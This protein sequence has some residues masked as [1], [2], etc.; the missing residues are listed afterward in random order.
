MSLV[1]L[2]LRVPDLQAASTFYSRLFDPEPA[3]LRDGYA[4]FAIAEPPLKLVLFQGEPGEDTRMGHLGV[5]VAT[6]DEVHAATGRLADAGPHH[7]GG[8]RHHLLS[9]RPGQSLDPGPRQRTLGGVR[10]ESRRNRADTAT[11]ARLLRRL[12]SGEGGRRRRWLLLTPHDQRARQRGRDGSGGPVAAAGRPARP[13][14]DADC[15]LGHRLLRLRRPQ[16]P[17]HRRDRLAGRG[18]HRGVLPR[19]GRLRLRRNPYRPRPTSVAPATWFPRLYGH[20]LPPYPPPQSR[21]PP[22][23]VIRWRVRRR[24]ITLI[25]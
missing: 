9:R 20:R 1:Q 17:D 13:L 25:Q 24:L 7:P 11:A 23:V 10:R 3:K 14:R 5:E 8:E 12:Y 21:W 22:A 16:P 19:A 15:E 4:N 2:A 6:T 18:D